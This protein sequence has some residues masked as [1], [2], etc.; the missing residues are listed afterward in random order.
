MLQQLTLVLMY[1]LKARVQYLLQIK[2]DSPYKSNNGMQGM[3]RKTLRDKTQ[4]R[5]WLHTAFTIK[6][7]KY[8]SFCS[9]GTQ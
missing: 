6:Y 9:E 3:N 8:G 2:S 5:E 1:M 4:R 7:A